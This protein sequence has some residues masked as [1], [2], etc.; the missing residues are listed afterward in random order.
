MTS[1]ICSLDMPWD[2]LC[3][4]VYNLDHQVAPARYNGFCFLHAIEMVLYMDHNEVVTFY[5]MESTILGHLA[6]NVNSYKI[7]HLGNVL[8][9]AKRYFQFGMYC[10]N[11]LDL[12]VVAIA[13]ALKLNLTIY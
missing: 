13:R 4:Y 9:G 11:V 10:G 3:L 8:K 12:I 1:I 6:T 5:G 2:Q 7:F